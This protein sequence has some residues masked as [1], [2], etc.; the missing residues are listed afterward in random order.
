MELDELYRTCRSVRRF[1]QKPVPAKVLHEVLEHARLVSSAS[2][3]LPLRYIVVKS[4]DMVAAMQPLVRWA[5]LLPPE[6]GAPKE[7]ELPTAFI[8]IIQAAGAGAFRDVDTGIAVS[9]MAM[10]AWQSGVGSCILGSIDVQKV[11][12][13]LHIGTAD[14]PRLAL[15][16]GY[17]A[18]TGYTVDVPVGADI[19]YYLDEQGCFVVPKYQMAD[20]VRIV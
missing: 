8:V 6:V 4:P 11:R 2:N 20:I 19:K 17:P 10:T 3:K 7:N 16:L 12:E 1:E 5:G 9:A 14:T 18:Q 15:A 13:L